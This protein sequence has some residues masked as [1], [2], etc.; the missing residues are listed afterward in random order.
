[1]E[2]PFLK[3]ELVKWNVSE[4]VKAGS[5]AS[6]QHPPKVSMNPISFQ[7]PIEIIYL[8]IGG[9]LLMIL[10]GVVEDLRSVV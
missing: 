4:D 1:M 6:T 3:A 7:R 8:I 10:T 9:M 2:S 5:A